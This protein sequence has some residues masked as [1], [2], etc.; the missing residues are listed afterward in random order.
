[1]VDNTDNA[2]APILCWVM[3]PSSI[4]IDINDAS[5]GSALQFDWSWGRW[6]A[7]GRIIAGKATRAPSA[8][9]NATFRV[10]RFKREDVG[11]VGGKG[12]PAPK[13]QIDPIY[14]GSYIAITAGKLGDV[15]GGDFVPAL[16]PTAV[17]WWGYITGYEGEVV[18]G[19]D[20]SYG[21]MTAKEVGHLLDRMQVIGW[22]R[23]KD[24]AYPD[25]MSSPPTANIAGLEEQVIGNADS[26][27]GTLTGYDGDLVYLF[28]RKPSDCGTDPATQPEKFWTRWRLLRHL[29]KVCRPR[30]LPTLKLNT[31]DFPTTEVVDPVSTNGLPGFLNDLGAGKPEVFN[32]VEPTYSG[33]LDLLAPRSLALGWRIDVGDTYWRIVVYSLSDTSDYGLPAN[34]GVN[35]DLTIDENTVSFSIRM[36]GDDLP[37]EFTLEGSRIVWGGT[38]SFYDDTMTEGWNTAA[39]ASQQAAWKAAASADPGYAALSTVNKKIRNRAVRH[40]PGTRDVFSRFVPKPNIN[41]D[42][43]LLWIPGDGTGTSRG[44]FVLNVTWDDAHGTIRSDQVSRCPYLPSGSLS[45]QLPWPEGVKGDGTDLRIAESKALPKYLVPRVFRYLSTDAVNPWRDLE[46]DNGTSDFYPVQVEVDSHGAALRVTTTPVEAIAKNHYSGSAVSDVDPTTDSKA[47]DYTNLVFSFAIESDQRISWTIRR[48]GVTSVRFPK[49]IT[50]EKY[51]CWAIHFGTIL[52]LGADG[53]PD[54][55]AVTNDSNG[56]AYFARNDYPAL[57]KRAKQ[58]AAFIFRSRVAVTIARSRPDAPPTW[59]KIGQMIA[60]VIDVPAAD[61]VTEVSVDS[62]TVIEDVTFEFGR[63]ARVTASSNLPDAPTFGGGSASA[64][65][66]GGVSVTGEGTVAQQVQRLASAM[67]DDGRKLVVPP[68]GG[69]GASPNLRLEVVDGNTLSDGVTLGGKWATPAPTTVPSLYNPNVDSSFID[70]IFRA[71]LYMDDVLQADLVLVAHWDGNS[72]PLIR[73]VSAGQSLG[74][75]SALITLPLV[76]DPTKTLSFYVPTVPYS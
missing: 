37:D 56:R 1:M 9:G 66:G 23:R 13:T 43:G 6:Q 17:L 49:R 2:M 25:P 76:S 55:V 3:Q 15:Y 70:G 14:A 26:A 50:D 64:S 45:H 58:I 33:Q 44:P 30:G 65:S 29:V 47:I 52:G 22:G 75:T 24:D 7:T 46:A 48:P 69:S 74:T 34:T 28:A 68:K 59:M 57:V 72:S 73:A 39:S 11:S 40:G 38:T 32:L 51:K 36:T 18:A 12:K 10:L 61:G 60:K 35:V 21:T 54:R 62:A 16:K 71:H 19:T 67:V 20:D 27:G 31:Q 63:T 4:P 8:K 53:R 42:I 41:G 5:K